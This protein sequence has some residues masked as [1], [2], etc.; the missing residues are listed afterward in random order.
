MPNDNDDNPSALR[1]KLED[2]NRRNKQL[3][4][5][6]T[7]TEAGLNHLSDRQRKTILRE[8]REDGEEITADNFKKVAKELGWGE[9][10]N[11]ETSETA[12]ETPNQ[13]NQN[14]TPPPTQQDG[15]QRLGM[16]QLGDGTWAPPE[17]LMRLAM[18]AQM[19]MQSGMQ[20]STDDG[21][22]MT[23]E[24]FAT[25]LQQLRHEH[26]NSPTE[27]GQAAVMQHIQRYG[28]VAGIMDGS[29]VE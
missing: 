15:E 27:V 5:R 13:P 7:I 18:A 23:P 22:V 26:R 20:G 11:S 9:A 24:L 14:G 8:M 29:L 4:E 16:I 28:H 2:A 17:E 6:L 1:Q 19:Q 21:T 12:P 25:K 3:E 10:P